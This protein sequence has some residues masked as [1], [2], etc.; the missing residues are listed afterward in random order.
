[1]KPIDAATEGLPIV[2]TNV[3]AEGTAFAHGV[4]AWIANTP[5]ELALGVR[6]LFLGKQR[7][8][9]MVRASQSFL[10]ESYGGS[11]LLSPVEALT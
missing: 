10:I 6:S 5:H 7:S 1:V 4:H 11:N 2:T 9:Q 3:G 8:K